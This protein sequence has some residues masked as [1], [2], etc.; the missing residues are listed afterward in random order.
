M[1]FRY[2]IIL[3]LLIVGLVSAQELDPCLGLSSDDC[4]T[5]SQ[6]S[7]NGLGG[8]E[9]FTIDF[10]LNFEAVDLPLGE[11]SS[12]MDFS[13]EGSIDVVP[14]DGD[15]VPYNF[16]SEFEVSLIQGRSDSTTGVEL[17]LFDDM[18]Y[19]TAS[20]TRQWMHVDLVEFFSDKDIAEQFTDLGEQMSEAGSQLSG[21]NAADL[22]PLMQVLAL[23]GFLN[24]ERDGDDFVFTMDLTALQA[25]NEDENEELMDMFIEGLSASDPTVAFILPRILEEMET[26]TIS[27]TQSVN[28]DLNI[29]QGY[30]F[31]FEF[32]GPLEGLAS[33]PPTTEITFELNF[34]F[35]NFDDV[36]EFEAPEDS[37]DMTELFIDTYKDGAGL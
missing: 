25:L 1:K 12:D 23:P 35:D 8:A 15:L 7:A 3:V 28:T 17:M 27:L 9:S 11:D 37:E 24:M 36:N 20:G 21:L 34:E 16:H 33:N 22:E 29:V 31:S 5:I 2:L 4:D 30:Q 26:G 19:F 14:G 6:A 10:E 13:M 32:V 18:L